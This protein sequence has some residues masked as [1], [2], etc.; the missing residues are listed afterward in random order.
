MTK[1]QSSKTAK[2]NKML[3]S[4]LPVA[5][6]DQIA[7]HLDRELIP[8]KPL[9]PAMRN[10]ERRAKHK[11][12]RPVVGEGAE[13]VLISVERGLLRHADAYARR[14]NKNRSE[15]FADALRQI[16]QPNLKRKAS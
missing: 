3:Y 14:H 13:K 15:L 2:R 6:L 16:I 11:R 9:T 8:T 4:K 7:S 5:T 12:G 1:K 10:Q